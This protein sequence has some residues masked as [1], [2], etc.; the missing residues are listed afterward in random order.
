MINPS[1][2]DGDVDKPSEPIIVFN[3]T[4][5][6][7]SDNIDFLLVNFGT[8]DFMVSG[9]VAEKTV[10]KFKEFLIRHGLSTPVFAMPFYMDV[11]GMNIREKEKVLDVLKISVDEIEKSI[12]EDY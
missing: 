8:P 9:N 7:I 3:I 5:M 6:D 1:D 12:E 4:P 11:K 10:D 2:L